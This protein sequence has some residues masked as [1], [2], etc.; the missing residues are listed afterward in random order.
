[1]DC[2]GGIPVIALA[3]PIGPSLTMSTN[4]VAAT[5][6]TL[7]TADQVQKVRRAGMVGQPVSMTFGGPHRSAPSFKR[8]G[9]RPGD[10]VLPVQVR[11]GRLIVLCRVRVGKILS[12]EEFVERHPDWFEPLSL[13]SDFRRMAPHLGSPSGRASY[14]LELWLTKNQAI[15]AFCPGEA[16]EVVIA[17][18]STPVRLDEAVPA[19]VVPA[20]RWQS[21]RAPERRIKHLTTDGRIERSISLQGIYRLT[22]DSAARLQRVSAG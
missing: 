4:Q 6:T 10:T 8:A 21:G 3:I 17:D 11:E 19:D 9:V 20:L 1:M 22:P 13:S 15:D 5:F 12:A 14:L 16:T 2:A 7:W 18:Q